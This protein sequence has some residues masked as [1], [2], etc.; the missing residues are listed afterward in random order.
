MG[1]FSLIK[2]IK[3][4]TV[5]DSSKICFIPTNDWLNMYKFNYEPKSPINLEANQPE[6]LV[7]LNLIDAD[8]IHRVN[9]SAIARAADL[10]ESALIYILK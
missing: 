10:T 2:N 7:K 8:K 6:V 3:S 5:N 4:I 9:Y 1:G